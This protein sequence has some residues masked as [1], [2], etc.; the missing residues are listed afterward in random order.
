MQ[1]CPMCDG[2]VPHVGGVILETT[3]DNVIAG[4]LPAASMGAVAM[5]IGPPAEVVDGSPTFIADATPV[6][7]M[8]S[9]TDHGGMVLE[10]EPTMLV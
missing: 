5:C 7:V 6:A 10:G 8:L 2:P 9:A 3:C 1:M 4:F